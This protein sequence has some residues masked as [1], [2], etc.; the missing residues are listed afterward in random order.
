MGRAPCA[1]PRGTRDN[2]GSVS[3]VFCF[4]ATYRPLPS[5][6]AR[7][8]L[9]SDCLTAYPLPSTP[10]PPPPPPLIS[11]VCVGKAN[12]SPSALNRWRIARPITARGG[13]SR[14][15]DELPQK[16]SYGFHRHGSHPAAK[17]NGPLTA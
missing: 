12:A 9:P 17:V 16:V 14:Q 1:G 5:I 11:I 15:Q 6:T 10:P 13:E 8:R 2:S 7:Y 3:S 4:H